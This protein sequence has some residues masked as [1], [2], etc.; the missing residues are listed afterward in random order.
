MGETV[1]NLSRP[2]RVAR[3]AELLGC[4]ARTVERELR[5]GRLRGWR[6]GSHWRV[7]PEAVAEYRE[8]AQARRDGRDTAS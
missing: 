5:L 6:V 2:L 3:V 7:S 1:K 8:R 4:T